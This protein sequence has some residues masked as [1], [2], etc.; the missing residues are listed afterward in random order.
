MDPLT[1]RLNAAALG[2]PPWPGH[3]RRRCR[4][5]RPNFGASPCLDQPAIALLRASQVASL[6]GSPC[7]DRIVAGGHSC[8]IRRYFETALADHE[9]A[10][11]LR[12]RAMYSDSNL[13]P[14]RHPP[15]HERRTMTMPGIDPSGHRDAVFSRPTH[16]VTVGNA[17]IQRK[18]SFFSADKPLGHVGPARGS[19][20]TSVRLFI[21]WWI[22]PTNPP[23]SRDYRSPW[24]GRVEHAGCSPPASPPVRGE[25]GVPSAFF[26]NV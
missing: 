21:Q 1:A 10:G 11:R 24:V 6:R 19:L 22:C 26:R 2:R 17:S 20:G 25:P 14:R 3:R 8:V 13:A 4:R 15:V 5:L 16:S 7:R 23:G 12:R 9:G 18:T